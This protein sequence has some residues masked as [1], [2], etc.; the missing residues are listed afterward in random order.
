MPAGA[1]R[2]A[3]LA[4]ALLALGQPALAQDALEAAGRAYDEGRLE[5]ATRAYREAVRSGALDSSELV[6]AHLRLGILAAL[7]GALDETE[8][9]FTIALALDPIRET[10]EE[11]SP[12][13]RA[14]FEALCESREGRRVTVAI[15]RVDGAIAFEVRDAPEGLARTIE[16]RGGEGFVARV[17][18][19]GAPVHLEPP[20]GALPIEATLLDQ[21]GN[22]IARAGARL[23]AVAVTATR[24]A[25]EE[26]PTR[27]LLESPWLWIVVGAIVIGIG[28]TVGVS[29]SGDRYLLQPPVI[30]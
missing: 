11:L 25:P 13:L 14:R 23:D 9:S 10:P 24:P 22:R 27:N 28:V 3:A 6:R 19:E 2:V 20:P 26:P 7:A 4:A 1:L 30:R 8:R 12:E 21:H 18:Y 15:S 17:P 29:A 5:E 16:V